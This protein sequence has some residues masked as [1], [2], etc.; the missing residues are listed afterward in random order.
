MVDCRLDI[1]KRA[2]AFGGSLRLINGMKRHLEIALVAVAL[3]ATLQNG[4]GLSEHLHRPKIF[5]PKNYDTTK[6]EQ[7]ERVLRLDKFKY[8][9]GITSYWEPKWPTTLAYDGDAQALSAFVAALREVKGMEVRLTISR[10]LSKETRGSIRTGSWWVEY[11]HTMPDTVTVRINLAA[12]SL[13]G[14]KF[15][16]RLPGLKQ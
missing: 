11:T 8:L 14:D 15:E 10:D 2:G 12:E 16:L 13:G 5:W 1:P 3:A 7:V 4:I 6:A 9:D